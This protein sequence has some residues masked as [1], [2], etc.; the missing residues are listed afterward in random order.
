MPQ[1]NIDVIQ[2]EEPKWKTQLMPAAILCSVYA[3]CEAGSL[4]QKVV[5]E[6]DFAAQT[7]GY[8][9][10]MSAGFYDSIS[11]GLFSYSIH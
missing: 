5:I 1:T 7:I 6:M 9:V 10:S 3:H 11:A 8:S 4:L 2:T